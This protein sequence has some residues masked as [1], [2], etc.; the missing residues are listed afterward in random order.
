MEGE[1]SRHAAQATFRFVFLILAGGASAAPQVDPSTEIR[2]VID[3]QVVAWNRGDVDG[4]MEGYVRSD[5]LE[6]VSNGK[7]TRGWKTVRDR[8]RRRCRTLSRS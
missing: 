6:F 7:I 5:R 4:Y 2:A 1:A 3:A 8:Y